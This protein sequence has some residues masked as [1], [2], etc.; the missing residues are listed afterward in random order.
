MYHEFMLMRR[1]RFHSPGRV[2][3]VSLALIANLFAA[4]VPLLHALV[5]D[6]DSHSHVPEH[7]A[8]AHPKPMSASVERPHDEIHPEV[9]HQDGQVLSRTSM[10]LGAAIPV[11]PFV[12]LFVLAS[13]QP[14]AAAEATFLSRAPPGAATARAPP[15]Q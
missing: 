6:R 13:S 3:F 9:L 2:L 1:G 11:Q 7:G 5:H 10:N 15:L 12:P 4:G 14:Y 8:F